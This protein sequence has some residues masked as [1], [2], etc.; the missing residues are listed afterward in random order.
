M[1]FKQ[2]IRKNSAADLRP[3]TTDIFRSFIPDQSVEYILHWFLENKVRLRIS[4]NRSS[5]SGDYRPSRQHLPPRISINN[6]LNPYDFLITLV[7]EMAHHAVWCA[8]VMTNHESSIR[9][10]RHYHPKPH[11]QEWQ[12]HFRQLMIPL[13]NTSVFP[14]DVLYMVENYFRNLRVSPKFGQNLA[15]VLK[16]YDKPDGK[17]FVENLPY[18]ALF[19]LPDGRLF[20]R[21]EKLRKRF[22]CICMNNDRIFLFSPLAQVYHD[23]R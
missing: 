20:R 14:P 9:M 21:K 12:H 11:G 4:L 18:N 10:R 23:E 15:R 16:K 19:R 6:N 13:M 22:R 2:Q 5:K 1:E 3:L 17:E 7:H 8:F